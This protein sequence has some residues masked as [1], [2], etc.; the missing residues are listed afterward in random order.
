M[1]E[2]YDESSR[3][4]ESLKSQSTDK[5]LILKDL[6]ST[7]KLG[8]SLVSELDNV[9]ILL[10]KGPLGSGKTSLVQG[11]ALGL[12]IYEPITSP[13]FAL[14][15]HYQGETFAL[16][17]LDLY[18]I[19]NIDSANQLFLQ[20]EEEAKAKRAIIVVEWPE[21]LSLNLAEALVMEIQYE[22]N[23]GRIAYLKRPQ[24]KFKNFSTS[25]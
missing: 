3:A 16:I 6:A 2:K 10:L 11:L 12:G 19:E 14:S 20:E 8:E 18:R 22:P 23:G 24:I 7:K 9:G 25:A 15:Q 13:T 17:H 21:R 5:G 4:S 1:K